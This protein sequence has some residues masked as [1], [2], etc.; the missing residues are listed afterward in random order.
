MRVALKIAYDGTDFFGF[1]RQHGRR[2]VQGLLEERLSLLLRTQT[3]VVGAG[4]TDRGVHASGQ[5]V[6]FD[7]ADEAS[8]GG[9]GASGPDWV[10]MRINK[11]LA[12]EVAV[13]AAALV[14]DDFSARFSARRRSYEYSCYVAEAPDPFGDRFSLWLASRP[15]IA[16]MR[17]AARAL[18]GEHDFS[19]FCR[20]GEG[21]LVRN[22][23]RIS[24]TSPSPGRIVFRVE[25]DSFCHQMVR[26]IVGTLLE[27]GSG[28]RD[29]SEVGK[30]LEARDRAAAGAV[31]PAR[32]LTLVAV[33]Y[34]PDPFR[35]PGRRVSLR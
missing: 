34:R 11:W 8:L 16:P 13:R 9:R 3:T 35:L 26:S 28:S 17:T 10:A 6:S 4:R 14:P 15:V 20:R 27:V 24:L 29:A 30:A 1:A 18:L 5:V 7:V 21:S 22:L 19:S 23:K 25:A 12:P 31:A 32:G 2:T 33:A